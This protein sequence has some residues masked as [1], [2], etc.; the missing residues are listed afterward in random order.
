MSILPAQTSAS[1][2]R[3]WAAKRVAV[4]DGLTSPYKKLILNLDMANR[5]P[6]EYNCMLFIKI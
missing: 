4:C 5:K 2:S 3:L 1:G 6:L